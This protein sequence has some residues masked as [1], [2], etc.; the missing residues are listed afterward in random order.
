MGVVYLNLPMN[1]LISLLW[2]ALTPP[3]F[4]IASDAIFT[5][6]FYDDGGQVYVGLKK[7]EGGKSESQ[8]IT[9]P[10]QGGARTRIPLPEEITNRDVIGLIPEKQK[11]FVLTHGSTSEKD[12]PMLHVFDNE[13]HTWKKLGQ[14]ACPAFTKA[15]LT[16]SSMT[17]YCE[18]GKTYRKRGETRMRVGPKTISY[19]GERLYRNG[20]WRFPEFMLRYKGVSLLL[21]GNAPTWDRLR[22]KSA[23]GDRVLHANEVFQLPAPAP[24]PVPAV[25]PAPAAPAAEGE[26]SAAKQE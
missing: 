15:K 14:I 23:D 4:A 17:F 11:V 2:L 1:H 12:G 18:T 25:N 7:E 5:T 19:K 20:T 10:F 6:V 24:T 21:E 22:L 13:K 9:F 26:T 16:S 8:V 3:S